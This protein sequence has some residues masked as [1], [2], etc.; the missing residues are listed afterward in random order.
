MSRPLKKDATYADLCA[1]PDNFVAEII[2]GELYATPRPSLP[3]ATAA[4]ALSVEL[5]GPFHFGKNGPGGWCLLGEPEL[6]LGAD[7]LVPDMAGWR[8]ERMPA[9]PRVAHVALAP[10]WV[11]EVLSPSTEKIDRQKKQS[12][13]AREGVSHL[14]LVNPQTQ[15]LE[16]LRLA[17]ERWSLVAVYGG[18]T[19]KRLEPFEAIEF[20]LGALWSE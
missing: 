18:D 13:Y 9:I 12:V 10:D 11:C 15:T 3:H 7:V 14:W 6:H 1:V 8:R 17:S 16:V 20:P 4:M 2:G 19:P 5:G